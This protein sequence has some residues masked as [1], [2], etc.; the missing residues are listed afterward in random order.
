MTNPRPQDPKFFDFFWE[1]SSVESTVRNK[2][3]IA[4]VQTLVTRQKDFHSTDPQQLYCPELAYSITRL[5]RGLASNREGA[6]QGFVL[7]LTEVRDFF[8]PTFQFCI[9]SLT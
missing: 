8:H 5:V 9:I 7:A 2:A 1:L 4:L 6:R 3:A